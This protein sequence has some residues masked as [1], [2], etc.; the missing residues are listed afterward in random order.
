M[1]K[2]VQRKALSSRRRLVNP[3][4]RMR[5]RSPILHTLPALSTLR[6][7]SNDN[8]TL[9]RTLAGIRR[10]LPLLRSSS[11][12]GWDWRDW[13]RRA[14]SENAG[15]LRSFVANLLN[16]RWWWRACHDPRR[17][18]CRVDA[19]SCRVW[20]PSRS[21]LLCSLGRNN[22]ILDDVSFLS[23]FQTVPWASS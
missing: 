11:A 20:R 19:S 17:C 10:H 8:S 18:R 1:T 21:L 15:T 12:M 7:R 3:E 9:L 22:P 14:A 23:P 13:S 5:D 2:V 16:E 6:K 4:Q